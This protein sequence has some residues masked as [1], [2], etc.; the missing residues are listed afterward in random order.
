MM[1]PSSREQAKES[2]FSILI[3]GVGNPILKDDG[4]GIH[5]LKMLEKKYSGI[6][7]LH[8]KELSTGGLSLAERF[9]GYDKV[10]LID[11]LALEN[12]T[13]GKVHK[14]SMDDFHSTIHQYCAHDCNLPTAYNLLEQQLGSE[15]LPQDVIIIGIEA[16]ELDEFGE[17]LSESVKG[18]I[19]KALAIIEQE[20][21]DVLKN[22]KC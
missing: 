22:E 17:T 2:D 13:P 5:V 15:S 9:I 1:T 11:A 16:E 4:V 20:L 18:A 21:R 12:G 19:P 14:L 6:P 8:F 7:A 3:I 10:I